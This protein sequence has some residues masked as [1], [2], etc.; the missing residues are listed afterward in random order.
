[1]L[2]LLALSLKYT[3]RKY[4]D[5]TGTKASRR[6]LNLLNIL[7]IKRD[8]PA[9]TYSYSSTRWLRTS[10]LLPKNLIWKGFSLL[11]LN[12]DVIDFIP[13]TYRGNTTPL[14][15]YASQQAVKTT[16]YIGAVQ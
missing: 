11:R 9:R 14:T 16:N 4:R 8:R 1:M 7:L 5:N 3:K 15:P 2:H 6:F 12:K 13:K 10:V